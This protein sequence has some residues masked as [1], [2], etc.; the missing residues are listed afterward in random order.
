MFILLVCYLLYTRAR[1][2]HTHNYFNDHATSL[3]LLSLTW[4]CE[5]SCFWI[6]AVIK[7]IRKVLLNGNDIHDIIPARTPTN[8]NKVLHCFSQP[9][10]TNNVAAP[11]KATFH[12]PCNS[13]FTDLRSPHAVYLELLT[14]N[15]KKGK[16]KLNYMEQWLIYTAYD[17]FQGIVYPLG[18]I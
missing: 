8:T 1:I 6:H 4:Q 12:I 3:P 17:L 16:I 15:S 18:A 5:P 14:E 2:W 7:I 10:F 13:L 9:L 11:N